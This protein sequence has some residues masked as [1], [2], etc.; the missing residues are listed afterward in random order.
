MQYIDKN[1]DYFL[2]ANMTFYDSS[3]IY[4]VDSA[5]LR[6]G[7]RIYFTVLFLL[8]AVTGDRCCSN[9]V[10]LR[11]LKHRLVSL[12][13]MTGW[14]SGFSA[15][16]A[17]IEQRRA[18]AGWLAVV[19]ILAEIANL[20]SDLL[21]SGL[22]KT[23]QIPSRCDFGT[24]V[25]LAQNATQYFSIPEY[26]QFA[27]RIVSQAQLTSVTNGGLSGIYWKANADPNFRAEEQDV[28]GNWNCY[29]VNQDVTY[30][31]QDF[32]YSNWTSYSPV[33]AWGKMADDL[34]QKGLLYSNE[35][36]TLGECVTTWGSAIIWSTNQSINGTAYNNSAN[37]W[38]IKAAIDADM[39]DQ[40][41]NSTLTMKSY[42]CTMNATAAQ[43]V[44]RNMEAGQTLNQWTQPLYGNLMDNAGA[45]V[46]EILASILE[47]MT[48]VG[49]AGRISSLV[50]P[51]G[52]PTIGCLKEMA[53]IPW[54]VF[55]LLVITTITL[56][57]M[58]VYWAVLLY[59]VRSASR[60]RARQPAKMIQE[61][62]P[63]GLVG[64]MKQTCREHGVEDESELKDL[65]YWDFSQADGGRVVVVRR[66]SLHEIPLTNM[67]IHNE[68]KS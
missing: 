42:H 36:G 49:T 65:G 33:D 48:M 1:G 9:R 14:L 35:Y 27:T 19:M 22:V 31:P 44:I 7:L 38:D 54:P 56:A 6:I 41:K 20:G 55:T 11:L 59:Q 25:V 26:E 5:K 29:D 3:L 67:L 47:I 10:K 24:G 66:Q 39:V 43:W 23:T 58:L 16:M 64:W 52:D 21:V 28:V 57:A 40:C 17:W 45:N 2:N 61:N 51:W 53:A 15:L 32:M 12:P 50:P 34:L 60:L 46:T 62:T 68:F 30:S 37:D 4:D 8:L 63:N 18:P 13:L